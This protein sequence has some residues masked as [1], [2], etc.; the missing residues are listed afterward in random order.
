MMW[1]SIYYKNIVF[2]S[3]VLL[4]WVQKS[5]QKEKIL[6]I[7]QIL[8]NKQIIEWHYRMLFYQNTH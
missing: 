5:L 6:Q 7:L 4:T 8:Y 1:S 3:R 2:I